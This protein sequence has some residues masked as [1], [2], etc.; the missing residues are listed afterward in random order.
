MSLGRVWGRDDFPADISR[1]EGA[2]LHRELGRREHSRY[3]GPQRQSPSGGSRK[4]Y[5]SGKEL[6]T[7]EG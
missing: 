6:A 1:H 7:K 3:W 5:V 4:V 2:K